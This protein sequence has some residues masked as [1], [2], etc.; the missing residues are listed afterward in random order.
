MTKY[1]YPCVGGPLDGIHATTEDFQ[2]QPVDVCP[3]CGWERDTRDHAE[4]LL[5]RCPVCKTAMRG[6]NRFT[7][8][9]R[10][11]VQ[12]NGSGLGGRMSSMLWVHKDIALRGKITERQA[13]I[14]RGDE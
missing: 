9:A 1:A 4:R 5:W 14:N 8:H 3:S 13:K 10:S 11:Y 7:E 12:Y 2:T 6:P